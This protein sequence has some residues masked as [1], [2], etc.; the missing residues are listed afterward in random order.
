LGAL[1]GAVAAGPQ[2]VK[3]AVDGMLPEM[4]KP[5]LSLAGLMD[6]GEIGGTVAEAATSALWPKAEGPVRTMLRVMV[7][8]IDDERDA[9]SIA[10]HWATS[11]FE[12]D[13]A[14]NRSWSPAFRFHVQHARCLERERIRRSILDHLHGENS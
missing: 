3:A 7:N 8:R 9:L 5:T 12:P 1:T 2:A 10:L 11:G 13:I 14:A 4:A 6:S